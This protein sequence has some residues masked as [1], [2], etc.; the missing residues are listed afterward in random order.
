MSFKF[1]IASL[2]DFGFALLADN[3]NYNN[4]VNEVND[5]L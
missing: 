1:F 4:E 5:T 2:F 3:I